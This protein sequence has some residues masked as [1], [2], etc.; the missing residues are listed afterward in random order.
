LPGRKSN[1]YHRHDRILP[2]VATARSGGLGP[3]RVRRSSGLPGQGR[4]GRPLGSLPGEI[5][6][7]GRVDPLAL[8]LPEATQ[9]VAEGKVVVIKFDVMTCRIGDNPNIQKPGAFEVIGDTADPI[10]ETG[11]L[12]RFTYGLHT[13]RIAVGRDHFGGDR[14]APLFDR[15][16]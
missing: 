5:A 12:E 9:G 10:K 15:P 1:Y 7:G 4:W 14:H 3:L 11:H 13:R 6:P 16:S 2:F 8:P